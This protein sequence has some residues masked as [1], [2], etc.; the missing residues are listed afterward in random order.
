ML[1]LRAGLLS[2]LDIFDGA[3][4]CEGK[5]HTHAYNRAMR[6]IIKQTVHSSVANRA[7]DQT[8]GSKELTA[9]CWRTAQRCTAFMTVF[10]FK[11]VIR[12]PGLWWLVSMY[13]QIVF[14]RHLCTIFDGERSGKPEEL[15]LSR[16]VQ[17]GCQE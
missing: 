14:T 9:S 10:L 12:K 13:K 6:P 17:T 4:R 3:K 15:G 1:L 11:K 7:N 16:C 2:P 8:S 5:A